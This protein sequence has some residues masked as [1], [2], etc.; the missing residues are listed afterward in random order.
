MS[1]PSMEELP[2]EELEGARSSEVQ[3]ML[4]SMSLPPME[5]EPG[6]AIS[7]EVQGMHLSPSEVNMT[8]SSPVQ[9]P[10]E[11]L[12]PIEV[13]STS[14][15]RST[16]RTADEEHGFHSPHPHLTTDASSARPSCI[17]TC[18]LVQGSTT[19]STVWNPTSQHSNPKS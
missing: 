5:E 18:D 3:D 6:E 7:C 2:F 8:N 11:V 1:L 10:S 13:Q 16:P 12:D 19:R 15:P 9:P 14:A 4:S 17:I